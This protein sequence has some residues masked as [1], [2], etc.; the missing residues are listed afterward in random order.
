P[1]ELHSRSARSISSRRSDGPLGGVG[2]KYP[3]KPLRKPLASVCRQPS[4]EGSNASEIWVVNRS[5]TVGWMRSS[6]DLPLL[7]VNTMLGLGAI[8]ESCWVKQPLVR[9]AKKATIDV[10]MP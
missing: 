4:T 7:C 2:A 8:T 6:K 10:R 3:A 5:G 9:S 1:M